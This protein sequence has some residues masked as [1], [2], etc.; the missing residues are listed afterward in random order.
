MRALIILMCFDIRG[1]D[2]LHSTDMTFATSLFKE[3]TE[4]V[5]IKPQVD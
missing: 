2:I 5:W 1:Q 3:I 4:N